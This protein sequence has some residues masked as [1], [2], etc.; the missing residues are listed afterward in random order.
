MN[1]ISCLSAALFL[2]RFNLPLFLSCFDLPRMKVLALIHLAAYADTLIDACACRKLALVAGRT[3]LLSEINWQECCR[4]VA[5]RRMRR[6][7]VF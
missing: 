7:R 5:N 6:M 4:G 3:F 2:Y 1:Y